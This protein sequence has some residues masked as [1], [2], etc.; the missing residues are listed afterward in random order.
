MSDNRSIIYAE[1]ER[2]IYRAS[3]IGLPVRCLSAARQSYDA[4]PPPDYLVEAAEAGN[5]FETI[6]KAQLR[7]QG[8]KVSGEQG[9]IELEILP[10]IILRGHLDAFHCIAP[11]SSADTILEVKSMSPRVFDEWLD[12]GFE[13]FPTY[14]AQVSVY[15][16]SRQAQATYA[17]INR[18]TFDMDIRIL[19]DYPVPLTQLI[20][21][22]SLIEEYANK[23]I[24]PECTGYKYRCAYDYMCD[25]GGLRLEEVEFGT[26][27]MLVDLGRRYAQVLDLEEDLKTRKAS[28][29]DEV[30]VALG[31]REKVHVPGFGFTQVSKTKRTLNKAR[32]RERLG[33]ESLDEFYD[34]ETTDP[35]LTIRRRST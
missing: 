11:E 23:G 21:K 15:M 29:R 19:D 20:D 30:R 2:I 24:L 1:G 16:A 8:Y 6:A 5:R 33:V 12:Y 25:F 17:C 26:E 3:A 4:L 27:E 32:L 10:N 22:V 35:V 18:E 7:I 34:E 28:L 13:H 9:E 31:G 14:A